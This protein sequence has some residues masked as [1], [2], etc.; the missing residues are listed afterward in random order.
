MRIPERLQGVL[1]A[2]AILLFTL[3]CVSAAPLAGYREG[4]MYFQQDDM[5]T[6]YL[7]NLNLQ[8]WDHYIHYG[9]AWVWCPLSLVAV[10]M[11]YPS[12]GHNQTALNEF[13]FSMSVQ[14]TNAIRE[15]AS[16]RHWVL[17]G[18][19]MTKYTKI[20]VRVY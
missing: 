7:R 9:Y 8:P 2:L 3:I 4:W 18:M 1:F 14:H 16:E 13:V 5:Q 11:L 6:T 15:Y 19:R 12:K 10:W 20:W 17:A